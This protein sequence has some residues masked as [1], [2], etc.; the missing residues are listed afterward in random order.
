MKKLK[1]YPDAR[2]KLKQIKQ[3]VAQKFGTDIAGKVIS[4][5]TKSVRDLQQFENKGISVESV[6]G[7]PCDY[8]ML[9]VQHNYVFYQIEADVIK[10]KIY[11]MKKRTLCGSSLGLRLL[12]KKQRIIGK[13]SGNLLATKNPQAIIN[14]LQASP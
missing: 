1:Y 13:I 14:N 9:Y 10:S 4:E 3:Y 2:E 11:A 8:R 7:I 12:Q 6:L 5:L